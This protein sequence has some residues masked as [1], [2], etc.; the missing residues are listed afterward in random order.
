MP[1]NSRLSGENISRISTRNMCKC[2]LSY[3]FDFS[4]AGNFRVDSANVPCIAVFMYK[5]KHSEVYLFNLVDECFKLLVKK[6][7]R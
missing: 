1:V 5:R 7:W 2:Q 4:L 6:T 3:L